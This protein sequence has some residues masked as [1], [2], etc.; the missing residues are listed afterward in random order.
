MLFSPILRPGKSGLN[1]S[2]DPGTQNVY[3]P[4]ATRYVPGPDGLSGSPR[5]APDQINVAATPASNQV[6]GSGT[7]FQIATSD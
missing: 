3:A 7:L 6:S 1:F 4:D 2:T 5:S